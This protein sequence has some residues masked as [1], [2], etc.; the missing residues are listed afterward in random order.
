MA[1]DVMIMMMSNSEISPGFSRGKI[2]LDS[3]V[4]ICS[5]HVT[6]ALVGSQRSNQI[7]YSTI[8]VIWFRISHKPPVEFFIIV[9]NS[10]THAGKL[11]QII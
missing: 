7:L 10:R 9:F 6:D 3:V 4:C 1:A 5:Y 8:N 2:V 11:F